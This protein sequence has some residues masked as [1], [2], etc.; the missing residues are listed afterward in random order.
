M[1]TPI[2]RKT[3]NSLFESL[4][5]VLRVVLVARVARVLAGNIMQR[6]KDDVTIH[7][8]NK[9]K[10][11]LWL[12]VTFVFLEWPGRRVDVAPSSVQVTTHILE[13]QGRIWDRPRTE[14]TASVALDESLGE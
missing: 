7:P 2:V 10:G 9:P 13:R 12:Q 8:A 6:W 3:Y 5:K 1:S 4:G 14:S 11:L